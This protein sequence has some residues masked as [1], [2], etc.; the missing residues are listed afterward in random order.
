MAGLTGEE[1][2]ERI[3]ALLRERAEANEE[4]LRDLKIELAERMKVSLDSMNKTLDGKGVARY[5]TLRD[6]AMA[7]GTTPNY[8]LDFPESTRA[9]AG[10]INEEALHGALAALLIELKIPEKTAW[11]VA[12]IA[13]RY[14]KAPPV[15]LV[16]P[17]SSAITRAVDELRRDPTK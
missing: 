3:L 17:R 8:L 2:G 12:E 4:R 5:L 6:L 1:F 11:Q 13:L 16:D 9:E 15:P 7:L 14:A 10:A